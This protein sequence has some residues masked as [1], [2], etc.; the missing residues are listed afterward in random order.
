MWD[1]SIKTDKEIEKYKILLYYIIKEI[2]EKLFIQVK[3]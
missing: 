3:N 1:N 2:Y